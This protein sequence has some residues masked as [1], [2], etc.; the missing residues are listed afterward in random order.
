[1]SINK[2]DNTTKM[3]EIINPLLNKKVRMNEKT[4]KEYSDLK[5]NNPNLDLLPYQSY[6][7]YKK[8]F[9]RYTTPDEIE[10]YLESKNDYI[11]KKIQM[12]CPYDLPSDIDLFKMNRDK[13]KYKYLLQLDNDVIK[14]QQDIKYIVDQYCHSKE[15][16]QKCIFIPYIPSENINSKPIIEQHNTYKNILIVNNEKFVSYLKTFITD[17]NKI[18]EVIYK[19]ND[20]FGQYNDMLAIVEQYADDVNKKFTNENIIDIIVEIQQKRI[21]GLDKKQIANRLWKRNELVDYFLKNKENEKCSPL[22]IYNEYY[23]YLSKS[24]KIIHDDDYNMKIK[25]CTANDLSLD[26]LYDNNIKDLG[27]PSTNN[28]EKYWDYC[29]NMIFHPF[30]KIQ[31]APFYDACLTVVKNIKNDTI[32]ENILNFNHMANIKKGS[33]IDPGIPNIIPEFNFLEEYIPEWYDNVYDNNIEEAFK[34]RQLI[35]GEGITFFL[36]RCSLLF[37]SDPFISKTCDIHGLVHDLEWN[38]AIVACIANKND[39]FPIRIVNGNAVEN[40]RIYEPF[41][42]SSNDKLVGSLIIKLKGKRTDNKNRY[43]ILYIYYNATQRFILRPV[44][45]RANI[46]IPGTI[47]EYVRALYIEMNTLMYFKEDTGTNLHFYKVEYENNFDVFVSKYS[48]EEIKKKYRQIK[49]LEQKYE[50][51]IGNLKEVKMLKDIHKKFKFVDILDNIQYG[52]KYPKTEINDIYGHGPDQFIKHY[53]GN[54]NGKT[55][56]LNC[57]DWE[58]DIRYDT[59]YTIFD[60]DIYPLKMHS[61]FYKSLDH[62]VKE[63]GKYIFESR[64]VPMSYFTSSN[65]KPFA[66]FPPELTK[67][68]ENEIVVRKDKTGKIY[69]RTLN[70]LKNN[71]GTVLSY[72]FESTISLIIYI[73]LKK[74]NLLPKNGK[75]IMFCKNHYMLDGVVYYKKYI[76]Y[77]YKKEDI[78]VYLVTYNYTIEEKTTNY[79]AINNF[80]YKN[81]DEPMNNEYVNRQNNL[82]NDEIDLALIDL[83]IKIPDLQNIRNPYAFPTYFSAII[84]SLS[85]LKIGGSLMLNTSYITNKTVFNF[86]LYLTCFFEETFLFDFDDVDIQKPYPLVFTCFI[87]RNYKKRVD[88]D[89]LLYINQLNYENDPTGGFQF[90]ITNQN[91]KEIL[92]NNKELFAEPNNNAKYL[93]SIVKVNGANDIYKKYKHYLQNLLMKI[94]FTYNNANQFFMN[95]DNQEYIKNKCAYVKLNSIYLA[96]KY[97]LPLL[98][99]IEKSPMDYFN[100]IL[101]NSIKNITFSKTERISQTKY[102]KLQKYPSI[103]CEYCSNLRKNYEL[104]E[105]TYQYI[106]KINYDKY[107]NIEL[108][109]NQQQKRLN[110]KLLNE[111]DM[112]INGREVSRAWLKMYQLLYDTGF[113]DNINTGDTINIFYIC[114]APGNF[115]N[116]FDYF[117]KKNTNIKKHNWTAQSLAPNLA[118][119]FDSYG[120][121]KATRNK[122]DL[123]PKNTG[124]ITDFNNLIYYYQKYGGADALISD[125]GEKWDPDS[126]PEN[127]ISIFQ[128]VY[129]LLIPRIGGN[130]VIKTFSA[131]YNTIYLSL[132]YIACAFYDKIYIFKS[133]INFWS[134]EIYVVGINKKPISDEDIKLILEFARNMKTDIFYLIPNIPTDFLKEYEK[135]IFEYITL[136][137]DIKKLFVFLSINDEIYESNKDLIREIIEHKNED[138]IEKYL[139]F[140]K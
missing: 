2:K 37:I 122:W 6:D 60:K 78:Y 58:W 7:M 41:I 17:Q 136:Y 114:E 119:F 108:F 130:F 79:L 125:C 106:D 32:R 21:Y 57:L 26:V 90:K 3:Y 137:T 35:L 70:F 100:Q 105:F 31:N 49:S 15:F 59:E 33:C 63:M 77:D 89:K 54:F 112:N 5:K 73:C 22:E 109:I 27:K 39:I 8:G 52:G 99:W 124:D 97:D 87:F 104:S 121:I 18:G 48:L 80:K 42:L 28:I 11:S 53:G 40:S 95:K 140:K 129:S 23:N 138:W 64:C 83:L 81:V 14:H 115:I 96:K 135:I 34:H 69:E 29:P 44:D 1:M 43:V 101:I 67:E 76:N 85:K 56:I 123:G 116:S 133:N 91:D 10:Q 30:D 127:D 98:E 19:F 13:N 139:K 107:K 126:S 25:K 102:I 16:D 88:I 50:Q 92:K 86:I 118:D 94:L 9:A 66:K 55:L 72:K 61:F 84:I 62:Y 65:F 113:V 120:F 20:L 132:L 45:F 4:F 12:A 38:K 71:E 47:I 36:R 117:I 128:L 111:Y 24:K 75:V 93:V 103:Q 51:I 131:N 110:K 82:I 134:P 46:I 74:Y 68:I